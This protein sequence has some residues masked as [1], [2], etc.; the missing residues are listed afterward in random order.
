MIYELS[1]LI[2][3]SSSQST[4]SHSLSKD[5]RILIT[6][7]IKAAHFIMKHDSLRILPSLTKIG[8]LLKKYIKS[9]PKL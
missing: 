4:A 8:I 2:A 6:E 3:F 7:T 1:K 9:E 5:A